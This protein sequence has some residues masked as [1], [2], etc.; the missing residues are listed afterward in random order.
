[1]NI[2]I[3]M[4]MQNHDPSNKGNRTEIVGPEQK[5]VQEAVIG[6]LWV[7]VISLSDTLIM[8][9]YCAQFSYALE[10]FFIWTHM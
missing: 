1:M 3:S 4:G 2:A 5:A 9:L 6:S 10:T 7:G 8:F